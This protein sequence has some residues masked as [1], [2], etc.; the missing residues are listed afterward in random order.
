MLK[1]FLKDRWIIIVA[2]V[3]LILPIDFVSDAI[4]MLGNVDD[5]TVLLAGLI[6]E[7]ADYKKEKKSNGV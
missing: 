7:Y 4:P 2:L 6:K 3:Y 1:E 5:F